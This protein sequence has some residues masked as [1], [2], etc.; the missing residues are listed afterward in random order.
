MNTTL[1]PRCGSRNTA[2]LTGYAHHCRACQCDFGF[3]DPQQVIDAATEVRKLCFYIGGAFG[4]SFE[5]D[6]SASRF[7]VSAR[8][9]EPYFLT[10]S[11]KKFVHTPPRFKRIIRRLF[12]HYHINDWKREYD[13]PD[14]FDGTQWNLTLFLKNKRKLRFSGSNAYP[15]H[16]RKLLR[17]LAPYFHAHGFSFGTNP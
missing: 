1:C 13:N 4:P 5:I 8:E 3:R 9:A 15:P 12:R 10:E 11:D 16:F 17:L 6:L 7:T 2:P 14:V